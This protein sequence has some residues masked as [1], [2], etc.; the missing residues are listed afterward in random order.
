MVSTNSATVTLPPVKTGDY[1]IIVRADIFDQAFEGANEANNTT[2]SAEIARA[3][4]APENV[5]LFKKYE[6]DL[7]KYAMPGLNILVAGGTGTG[8]HIG[9]APRMQEKDFRAAGTLFTVHNL[10]YHGL[11]GPDA[12]L[13]VALAL[14]CLAPGLLLFSMNNILARA[15]YALNDIK[16]PMKISVACL[17]INLLLSLWLVH[18]LK[19]AGLAL[20]NMIW[21]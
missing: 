17:M 11:F 20:A 16:T 9:F 19:E 6:A 4:T 8:G 5:A 14:A 3:R 12:T 2:A 18:Y 10:G 7:K 21:S 13:R 15:F 1:R